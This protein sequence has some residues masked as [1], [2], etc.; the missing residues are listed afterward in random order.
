[1]MIYYINIHQKSLDNKEIQLNLVC[2]IKVWIYNV[3][4]LVSNHVYLKND[5]FVIKI[6]IPFMSIS[7]NTETLVI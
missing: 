4:C 3:Y 6:C 5:D 7:N 2:T 1:M